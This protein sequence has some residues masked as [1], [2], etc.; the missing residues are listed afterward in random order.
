MV[1]A[2]GVVAVPRAADT[3]VGI[4]ASHGIAERAFNGDVYWYVTPHLDL[5]TAGACRSAV[6]SEER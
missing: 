1:V 3:L 6:S 4:L 2:D 5:S